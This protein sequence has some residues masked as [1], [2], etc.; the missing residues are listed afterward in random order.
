MM[1]LASNDK[2]SKWPC[3]FVTDNNIVSSGTDE[4]RLPAGIY[5][6][7]PYDA[8]INGLDGV[9]DPVHW[10]GM[11]M[12]VSSSDIQ[13]KMFSRARV[14]CNSDV[15]DSCSFDA[16]DCYE[17]PENTDFPK[18]DIGSDCDTVKS[19]VKIY[20]RTSEYANFVENGTPVEWVAID[21]SIS[22][23]GY[24]DYTDTIPQCADKLL[25]TGDINGHGRYLQYKVEVFS[26]GTFTPIIY[27]F[28][29][30]CEKT[31]VN[32]FVFPNLDG[33]ELYLKPIS[34]VGITSSGSI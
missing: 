3:S 18:I 13:R 9:V 21:Y 33:R 28:D 15:L 24:G 7:S 17:Q 6:S 10:T 19:A 12:Y 23:P 29:F 25:C 16:Y 27:S 14:K 30:S 8:L 32:D 20:Y 2:S 34:T 22:V 31:R 4:Q 1:R 26:D 5:V 11:S